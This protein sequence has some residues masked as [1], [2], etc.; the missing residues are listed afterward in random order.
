LALKA[1]SGAMRAEGRRLLARHEPARALPLLEAAL[2]RGEQIEQQE[3]LATLAEMK[4]TEATKLLTTWVH[5]LSAGDVPPALRLDVIEAA[6]ATKSADLSKLLKEYEARKPKNNPLAAWNEALEGGNA[7]AGR[8]I[9]FEKAEI[10][11]LRCHKINGRGGDVGPDLSS[12]GVQQKR[13]YLLESIVDPNKQIAKGFETVILTLAD[14]KIQSGI[15]KSE[16]KKEVRLMTPEGQ[17]LTIRTDEIDQRSRG[18][19]A[20]PE[21][22]IRHLSRREVRDLVEF[23][24][25]QKRK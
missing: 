7:E 12:I 20:M 2:D 17:V 11:C 9:F 18:K 25:A 13:D 15:L 10:S 24:A 1:E 5:R 4:R 22:I 21:D 3:A 8:R 19:S 16:T 23:L 6:L 14:G